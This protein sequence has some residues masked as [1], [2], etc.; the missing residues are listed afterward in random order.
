M[1][2][3]GNSFS[4]QDRG[5][6]KRLVRQLKMRHNREMDTMEIGQ[7]YDNGDIEWEDSGIRFDATKAIQDKFKQRA[8][9]LN[10]KQEGELPV[11]LFDQNA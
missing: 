4:P 5:E 3:I 10:I 6:T 9:E 7:V 2:D 11:R 8:A 1:R